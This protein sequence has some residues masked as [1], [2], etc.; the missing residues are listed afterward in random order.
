MST[1][2]QPTNNAD[3]PLGGIV[4]Q[5]ANTLQS[6]RIGTDADGGTH[7]YHRNWHAVV[8]ISAGRELEH[9]QRL[10]DRPLTDWYDFV[11]ESRGWYSFGPFADIGLEAAEQRREGQR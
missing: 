4:D 10:G 1:Q 5:L 6:F 7:Y 8:V 2:H 11:R 9:V 3:G